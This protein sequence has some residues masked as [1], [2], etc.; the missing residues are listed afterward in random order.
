MILFEFQ[1]FTLSLI[2]NSRVS[3]I[4]KSWRDI[5]GWPTFGC[6]LVLAGTSLVVMFAF[7]LYPSCCAWFSSLPGTDRNGSVRKAEKENWISPTRAGNFSLL[8]HSPHFQFYTDIFPF[9]FCLK[10]KFD[11]C[12]ARLLIRPS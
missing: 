3:N 10:V 12:I 1:I 7:L 2:L 4:A 11:Y 9:L 5:N 8:Y 6:T